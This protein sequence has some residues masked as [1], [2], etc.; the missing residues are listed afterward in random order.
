MQS[1]KTIARASQYFDADGLIST[2]KRT[3]RVFRAAM[4]DGDFYVNWDMRGNTR[5]TFRSRSLPACIYMVVRLTE[6][7]KRPL[8]YARTSTG[9]GAGIGARAH[10]TD[11]GRWVSQNEALADVLQHMLDI[12]AKARGQENVPAP[13]LQRLRPKR[14][15]RRE[16]L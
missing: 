2:E 7:G 11:D 14:F 12:W 1:S 6:E 9:E 15:V 8:L 10:K 13:I 5:E 16:R 4:I 3:S